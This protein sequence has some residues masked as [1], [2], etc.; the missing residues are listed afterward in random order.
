M[1]KDYQDTLTF[2]EL[3]EV[4]KIGRTKAYQLLKDKIIPSI[5]VGTNYIIPKISVINYLCQNSNE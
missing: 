5:K 4:L 1:L 3:K 2:N